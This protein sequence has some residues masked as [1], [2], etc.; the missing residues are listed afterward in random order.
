MVFLELPELP[1]L[2]LPDHRSFNRSA[3]ELTPRVTLTSRLVV[4]CHGEISRLLSSIER[5]EFNDRN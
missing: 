1:E 5:V 2:P 4:I 3:E